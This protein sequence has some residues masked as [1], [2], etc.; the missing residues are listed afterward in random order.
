MGL[1]MNMSTSSNSDPLTEI[2]YKSL[3]QFMPAQSSVPVVTHVHGLEVQSTSD[4]GPNAWFTADGKHGPDYNTYEPTLPNATVDYYP[5]AQPATTLWYHDHAMGITRLNVVAGLAGFYLIRDPRNG[6]DPLMPSG[7]YEMPLVVQDRIF[8]TDGSLYFPTN[9]G[10]PTIHPYW[11]SE[12][13]GNVI[14]VN[15]KAWPNMNVDRGIYRFRLL[16]GSN[17]RFYDFHFSNGMSFQQIGTDGG[18]L[19]APF[20]TTSI[21]MAP[22]E[23]ADILVDFSNLAPGTK[24]QLMNDAGDPYPEGDPADPATVGTIMQFTVGTTTGIQSL[25][26]PSVLN[27]TLAGTYP[28]LPSPSKTRILP[29][30]ELTDN[31]A[32]MNPIIGLLD[33]QTYDAPVSEIPTVGSTEEWTF[34]NTTEDTH[35][36]HLH[37]VQFQVVSRQLFD[38]VAYR[39]DWL[40]LNGGTLPFTAPTKE[41]D[42]HPYLKGNPVYPAP[43]EMGWKD[44]I[45]ATDEMVTT[46]R[47]RFAPIDGSPSYPFDATVG[48]GYDW[49]CHIIDH[50]D[51]EM[52]R[53]YKLVK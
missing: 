17:S 27:Q 22:A 46:I 9:S 5:N 16:D 50:E 24:I 44:T 1:S 6:V 14:M 40:K 36:I 32:L 23:R 29:L 43:N 28:T 4:G 47:V 31:S 49:H 20:S 7:K 30:V 52:M 51:N 19:K 38:K 12:F 8:A 45:Q 21:L 26:L 34:V 13:V 37:L 2:L 11:M 35:P 42:Y 41:L 3:T 48:P 33:G 53:P 25:N 39:A 15:G 10:V 18:Y